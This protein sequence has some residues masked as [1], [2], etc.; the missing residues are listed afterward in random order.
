MLLNPIF[1][2]EENCSFESIIQANLTDLL[3][4]AENQ[5]FN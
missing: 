3:Q 1:A 5:R 4:N 2:E